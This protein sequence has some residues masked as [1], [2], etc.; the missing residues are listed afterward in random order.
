[1]NDTPIA[2]TTHSRVPSRGGEPAEVLS[3]VVPV[4]NEH[5]TL[6]EFHR[7]LAVVL[8]DIPYEI[9]VLYVDDG[10]SDGSL[11]ILR[12][13]RQQD[14]RITLIELSRNFGKEAAMTAGLDYAVGDAVII[15]DADL[16]DPPEVIPDLI[17]PWAEGRAEVVYAQ[18]RSRAGET[19]LKRASAAAFYRLMER[20]GRAPM[21]RNVGDF[22]L[23]SREVVRD[24][25]RLREQHR[26]MKG[27]FAWVGYRQIAVPYDR[28]PRFAG[29]SKWNYLKL[30]TFS[31]EGITSFTTAPLKVAT[32]VGLIVAVLAL[33]FGV[34]IIYETLAHGNPVPGYP[35]LMVVVLFLGGVQLTTIGILGEYVGRISDETKG[36]PLYLV[37]DRK[38][39]D[40]AATRAA[41]EPPTERSVAR[42]LARKAPE[43]EP[44]EAGAK[45]QRD[46][47][48]GSR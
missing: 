11:D 30:W 16:Q 28:D 33:I 1:V 40:T 8:A 12:S 26:F 24:L 19:W 5:Q 9:E 14:S 21:P 35:S 32:Y 22:R 44:R 15:I 36:R 10:S 34:I 18:R 3:V 39:A 47:A 29:E 37:R 2:G 42:T 7:R 6:E 27:L 31:I 43:S 25:K 23:L 46:K 41:K 38:I 48:S 45:R 17:A 13:L 4:F 20:V